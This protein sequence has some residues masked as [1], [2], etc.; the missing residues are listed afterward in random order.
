[1]IQKTLPLKKI[2]VGWDTRESSKQLAYNF[3]QAFQ[4]TAIEISYIDVCPIDFITAGA[5]AFDFDFSV[6]FTGSHNP[7]NWTGLL[8]HTVGGASVEGELVTHIV[9]EYNN[10]LSTSYVKPSVKLDDYIN[11]QP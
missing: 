3:L 9:K 4:R 11:F 2:L 6:M 1:A 10:V 8:M 5:H 7:W